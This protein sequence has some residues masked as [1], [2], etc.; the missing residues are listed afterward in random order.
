MTTTMEPDAPEW[1][2]WIKVVPESRLIQIRLTEF[3][4]SDVRVYLVAPDESGKHRF[5]AEITNA[6]D[7][8]NARLDEINRLVASAEWEQYVD[9]LL[10]FHFTEPAPRSTT[11]WNI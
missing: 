1:V 11:P 2:E 10:A 9:S 6:F 8:S 3:G 7:L 4:R 5:T